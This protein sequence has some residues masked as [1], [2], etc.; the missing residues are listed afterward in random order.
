MPNRKYDGFIVHTDQDA[1]IHFA[2]AKYVYKDLLEAFP[3]QCKV[4]VEIK[5]RRKPRSLSQNDFY[6]GYFLQYEIDCFKEYWGET[7][8]KKTMHEWNKQQFFGE[9]KVIE[10]TGEVIRVPGSSANQ[11]TITFEE[12]LDAAREWFFLNF[13]WV[14]PYP[15]ET[16]ELKF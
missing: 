15:N 6:W 9:E 13:E 5:S 11:S 7:Y 3:D 4:T 8:D 14:I 12:K 1:T 16:L 2:N 10:K